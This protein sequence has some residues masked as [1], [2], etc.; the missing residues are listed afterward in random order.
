MK[1]KFDGVT[2]LR[3]DLPVDVRDDDAANVDA[4]F[5]Y[6]FDEP[7]KTLLPTWPRFWH[8]NN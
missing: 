7:L 8:N 3:V 5:A 4:D 6:W 1:I 2:H